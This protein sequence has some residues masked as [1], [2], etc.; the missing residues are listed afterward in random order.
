MKNNS[1]LLGKRLANKRGNLSSVIFGGALAD[2]DSD[3]EEDFDLMKSAR[4]AIQQ[5]NASER[6]AASSLAKQGKS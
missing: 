4:A 3:S 2:D 1:T 5:R 6:A